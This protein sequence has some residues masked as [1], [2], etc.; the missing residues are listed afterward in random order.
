[1]IVKNYEKVYLTLSIT[2]LQKTFVF[3]NTDVITYFKPTLFR[4]KWCRIKPCFNYI[5]ILCCYFTRFET[6]WTVDRIIDIRSHLLENIDPSLIFG[7]GKKSL[8]TGFQCSIESFDNWA[9]R[10]PAHCI[11]IHF[12][13]INQNCTNMFVFSQKL[14]S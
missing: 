13:F 2:L 4:I 7:L 3:H 6:S 8:E 5:R 10:P 9:L 1:M 11:Y 14:I 12:V